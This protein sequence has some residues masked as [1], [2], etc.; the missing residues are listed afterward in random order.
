[1]NIPKLINLII[2]R[3]QTSL[4]TDTTSPQNPGT[5]QQRG[6]TSQPQITSAKKSTPQFPEP[7]TSPQSQQTNS[8]R[9]ELAEEE[10]Q[11]IEEYIQD[12]NLEDIRS[13]TKE[14]QAHYV[15]ARL[16]QRIKNKREGKP[17]DADYSHWDIF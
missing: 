2:R 17:P 12:M 6:Q 4:T 16:K 10:R 9:F 7:K 5:H 1:M 15:R 8:A 11:E 13:W 3:L 14:S